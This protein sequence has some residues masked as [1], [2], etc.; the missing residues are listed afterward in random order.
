MNL[1]F[2]FSAI[3]L[4]Y[5]DMIQEIEKNKRLVKIK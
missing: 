3:A 4:N 5:T 2:I 1:D